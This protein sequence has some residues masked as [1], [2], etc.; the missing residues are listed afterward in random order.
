MQEPYRK[1]SSDSILTSTRRRLAVTGKSSTILG[2]MSLSG[3]VATMTIEEPTDTDIFLAYVEHLLYP[4]LKPGDVVVMD[5][6]SAHKAPAVCQWIEKAGAELLYF[7]RP[8]LP[9]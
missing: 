2:A 5:N 1:G 7:C 3:M 6:F 4:V 9:I 8:I